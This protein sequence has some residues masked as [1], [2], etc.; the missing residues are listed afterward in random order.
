V[1]TEDIVLWTAFVTGIVG[2]VVATAS[3]LWQLLQWRRERKGRSVTTLNNRVLRPWSNIG[4]TEVL[5]WPNGIELHVPK[6]AFPPDTSGVPEDGMLFRDIPGANSALH[7]L[8]VNHSH[9][10]EAWYKATNAIDQYDAARRQRHNLVETMVSAAL[11]AAYPNLNVWAGTGFQ[12]LNCYSLSAA[13]TV[14]EARSF[15]EAE[16]SQSRP[17]PPIMITKSTTNLGV[18]DVRYSLGD[19]GYVPVLVMVQQGDADEQ[20]L[21]SL[22]RGWIQNNR[23]NELNRSMLKHRGEL[24]ETLTT[25]KAQLK[26]ACLRIEQAGG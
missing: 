4:I 12:P 3:F 23:V 5:G 19:A 17:A 18:G 25:F 22:I 15:R 10:V 16:A 14:V 24:E 9:V 1:A 7:Y 13:M 11:A 6:D 26:E 8:T 20:K 2:T 21:L